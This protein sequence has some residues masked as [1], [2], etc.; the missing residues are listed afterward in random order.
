MKS[1]D[2][3][4]NAKSERRKRP[5]ARSAKRPQSSS[6]PSRKLFAILFHLLQRRRLAGRRKAMATNLTL[7]ARRMVADVLKE[8]TGWLNKTMTFLEAQM[9]TATT[10]A[11]K[12]MLH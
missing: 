9:K 6:M 2:L 11:K 5:S 10:K 8:M 3:G 1:R 7:A 4:R 12:M